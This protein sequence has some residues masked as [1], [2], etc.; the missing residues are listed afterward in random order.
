MRLSTVNHHS[1][2][3]MKFAA[4]CYAEINEYLTVQHSVYKPAHLR[5]DLASLGRWCWSPLWRSRGNSMSSS[6]LWLQKSLSTKLRPD[7]ACWLCPPA[8]RLSLLMNQYMHWRGFVFVFQIEEA[9]CVASSGW[10]GLIFGK[11]FVDHT[12]SLGWGRVLRQPWH[13]TAMGGRPSSWHLF[14]IFE[15]TMLSSSSF[16]SALTY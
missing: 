7:V 14:F 16:I 4:Q 2:K 6:S 3:N 13:G 11:M 1:S 10:H 5:A 9:K 8:Q 15:L 12:P